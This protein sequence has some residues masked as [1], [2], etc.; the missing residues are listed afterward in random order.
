MA[1]IIIPQI[2]VVD[3]AI[4]FPSTFAPTER[5]ELQRSPT[6]NLVLVT[7]AYSAGAHPIDRQATAGA[8]STFESRALQL[9]AS[10][11]GVV[12]A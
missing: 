7:Y 12:W 2:V 9:L 8:G 5:L 10:A 3:P 11:R 6:G 4:E 1:N